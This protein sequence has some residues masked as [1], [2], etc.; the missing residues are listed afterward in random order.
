MPRRVSRRQFVQ[1]SGLAA[2]AFA[3]WGLPK[4]VFGANERLNVACIGVGNQGKY[5]LEN[6]KHENIVAMAD[7]DEKFLAAASEHAPKA[8]KFADY[9]KMLGEMGKEIDAVVVATP[10]HSHAYAA[11]MAMNMGKHCYCE[12]PL[13]HNVHEVRLMRQAAKQNNLV[14]QMGTQIHA[15]ENYRRVVELIKAGA[16]G[17]VKETHHWVDGYYSGGDRPKEKQSAPGHVNWDLWLGPAPHRDYHGGLHP[18]S[19]RGWWDFG[20]GKFS[21]MACHHM[22]IAYWALDLVLPESVEAEGPPDHPESAPK[23]QIVKFRYPARGA[24]P[25]VHVSWYH[26]DK[27]PS[28]FADGLIPRNW[29]NSLFVGEK[30]MLLTDYNRH[31]LLPEG[32]FKDYKRPEKS[33]PKSIGHHREWTEACKTGGK[34]LCNFDYSG[35]LAEAVQLGNVAYRTGRKITYD[36]QAG[37]A[38]GFAEADKFIKREYRKGWE[39]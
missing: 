10:D 36:P 38:V 22:D 39:L 1:S 13:A 32:D 9:R 26:G 16:I 25:P 5:D 11:L 31:V 23:W 33:I 12:K 19:W 2:G 21:D 17:P 7:I 14:T 30:G 34:T 15:G 24:Q 29:G 18:F 35:A 37:K 4:S 20:G 28:Q 8:K 6:V 27:R 3:L